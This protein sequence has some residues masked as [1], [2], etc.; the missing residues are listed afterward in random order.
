LG[1]LVT[2]TVLTP[3]TLPALE[4]E[5]QAAAD[6][7][8]PFHVVHFDVH[9]IYDRE[10]GLGGLCFEDPNEQDKLQQRASALVYADKL[11]EVI[12][13]HR[14]PLAFLEACQSAQAETDPTA[15]VAARLLEAG[16][17]SVVAMSH[18][19]LVETAP[20]SLLSIKPADGA[21]GPGEL[22]GNA[23][24][25]NSARWTDHGCG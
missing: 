16:V 6:A 17:T 8:Q 12:R 11:A 20:L 19:V 23:R 25:M 24:C 3:P 9:Y 4:A 13:D 21:R 5:L 14:I 15:S 2:L 22:A 1:D 7:G 10:H 18:S